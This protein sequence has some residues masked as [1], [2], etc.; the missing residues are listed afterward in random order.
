M[1]Q[2]ASLLTK[3]LAREDVTKITTTRTM[4]SVCTISMV[5]GQGR[6]HPLPE[7]SLRV[8]RLS[9]QKR[10]FI[11]H[12]MVSWLCILLYSFWIEGL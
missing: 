4:R 3:A 5:E 10:I 7:T 1:D 9:D 2:S 12:M 11:A 6:E 8:L